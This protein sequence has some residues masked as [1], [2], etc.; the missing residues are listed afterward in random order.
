MTRKGFRMSTKDCIRIFAS[1]KAVGQVRG[2]TFHKSIRGSK[3]ILRKPPGLAVDLQSLLDA[4]QAGATRIQITD[5]ESGTKYS[6]SISHLKRSGFTFDRG[7]GRQI[8][9][10]LDAWITERPGAPVQLG[11]FSG[12]RAR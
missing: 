5:K 9:L 4:E 3:H 10:A 1:G 11:L 8:G 2:D 12:G 7:F 6:T